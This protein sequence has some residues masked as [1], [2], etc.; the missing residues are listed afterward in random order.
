M[1]YARYKSN[2]QKVASL[3]NKALI[4]NE[5]QCWPWTAARS[6]NGYGK[7]GAR[8]YGQ[9]YAHRAMYALTVGVIPRGLQVNHHCDNR[10]CINPAHLYLG[11][12]KENM[13]DAIR[14]KRF[15]PV[16][17]GARP[18]GVQ[19]GMARL[20]EADIRAI[21]AADTRV[22]GTAAALSAKYGVSVGH[23]GAIRR[24]DKWAE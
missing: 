10:L 24:G 8:T 5:N 6:K 1:L 16:P 12:Q 4:G 2:A 11:T 23:I 21:R 14:R 17:A 22:R 15:K 13:A 3:L 19:H 7:V 18:R 9:G 20:A